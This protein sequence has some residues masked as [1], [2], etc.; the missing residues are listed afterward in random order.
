MTSPAEPAVPSPSGLELAPF[1]ALR[2][3]ETVTGP[4]GPLTSPPY[5]VIDDAGVRHYESL[6]PYNVVR[7]ILPREPED[8][9]GT[10]YD[11]A[12]TLLGRWRAEGVLRPDAEPALYAYELADGETVTRGLVGA[13]AL[14][15]PDAGIVLPHENTMSGIVGD[16]VSLT[17]AT[18]CN[19]EPIYLVYD[20]GGVASAVVSD[21]GGHEPIATATTDDGVSHRLWAITDP[22][23]LAAVAADL[24]T[25][26]A[27]IADGHHRYAN[28][29]QHQAHR[30]AAGDGPGPWDFGLAFLV[31]ATAFG[32]QVHPIHRVVPGLPAAEAAR[33]AEAAFTVRRL[34]GGLDEALDALANAGKGGPAFVLAGPEGRWLVTDPD[35]AA[36]AAAVPGESSAAWR[37]L[38]VTVAHHLLIRSVWQ[39]VDDERHVW[40][41][42]DA[43]AAEAAAAEQGGTALLLNATPVEAVIAVAAAGERMPRKSTFFTPKPR[44]GLL[45]RAYADA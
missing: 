25:R 18:Q 3:D 21:V 15:D 40:F 2:Y 38:D 35:Q 5:D 33:R 1:R 6:S 37:A 43:P 45:L 44:T 7:L 10:R 22:Q 16:R 32:P 39:V 30:H 23:I 26:R 8:G 14:V 42:H 4:L 9:G 24:H 13:L 34:D 20:G 19:T 17:A 36:L 27:V 28:F 41:Q 11:A 31:D 29:R 12:A